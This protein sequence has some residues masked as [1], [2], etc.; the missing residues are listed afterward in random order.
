VVLEL[1]E[2]AD[3]E[4]VGVT[5]MSS[6]ETVLPNVVVETYKVEGQLVEYFLVAEARLNSHNTLQQDKKKKW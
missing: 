6:V 4:P 1:D 5:L 3:T 2:M